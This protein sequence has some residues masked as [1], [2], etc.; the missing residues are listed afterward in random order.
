[1]SQ[2][3]IPLANIRPNPHNPRQT[4]DPD[5]IDELA[6]SLKTHGQWDAILVRP[7]PGGHFEVVAGDCRLAAATQLGWES[8]RATVRELTDEQADY[9]GLDTNLKRRSLSELDEARGL[10]RMMTEHGWT[11]DRTAE[12][13]GKTKMWVSYRLSLLELHPE[14]QAAVNARLLTPTHGR[15]IA[16]APP[17]LQPMI[18]GKVQKAELNTR[19]TADLVRI[20]T[21]PQTPPEVKRAV[22]TEPSLT[23]EHAAII[24]KAPT[25]FLREGLLKDAV[26]GRSTPA[27]TQREV[28]TAIKRE[29]APQ[30]VHVVRAQRRISV[31]SLLGKALESLDEVESQ[32]I[33]DLDGEGLTDAAAL[34]QRI[35]SRVD[36]VNQ[37][38]INAQATRKGKGRGGKVVAFQGMRGED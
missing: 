25:T 38:I 26:S 9:L 37:W 2:Q 23:P 14:V 1:M 15:E 35:A 32:T 4:L 33:W 27:E 36:K 12:A 8:I 30:S 3:Q 13:F 6:G 21:D 16:S 7:L 19:E 22:L 5:Y 31:F 29:S 18:A 17:E 34:I 10:R 11:Q 24:A 28:D 20:A